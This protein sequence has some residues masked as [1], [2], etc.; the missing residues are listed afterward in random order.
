LAIKIAKHLKE[1]RAVYYLCALYGEHVD[2]RIF[3]IHHLAAAAKTAHQ[4]IIDVG[5]LS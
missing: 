4:Y 2:T 3:I 1:S 5:V